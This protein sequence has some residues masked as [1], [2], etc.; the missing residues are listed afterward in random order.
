M[1]IAKTREGELIDLSDYIYDKNKQ[2]DF[3]KQ[4]RLEKL[5]K[6]IYFCVNEGCDEELQLCSFTV[7]NKVAP[8]FAKK[9]KYFSEK[10][11][12]YHNMQYENRGKPT[13]LN[14]GES[15]YNKLLR[16]LGGF[17]N[18]DILKEVKE[19]VT[20]IDGKKVVSSSNRIKYNHITLD[21]EFDHVLEKNITYK[22]W[23]D[24]GSRVNP[25]ICEKYTLINFHFPKLCFSVKIPEK[26]DILELINFKDSEK[27][28]IVF[29]KKSNQDIS[30]GDHKG[31]PSYPFWDTN[32]FIVKNKKIIEIWD[33]KGN[34]RK[35]KK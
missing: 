11:C 14:N 5:A 13:R 1:R 25:Y 4:E 31:K 20:N 16:E 27:F 28:Y 3:E 22:V 23:V 8:Y 9:F 6:G 35:I 15:A 21:E 2:E 17:E 33:G 12:E 10:R 19:R 32:L 18:E 29:I 34:V 24:K 30:A 7:D 26:S